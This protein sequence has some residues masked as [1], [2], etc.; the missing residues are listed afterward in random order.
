MRSD[1]FAKLVELKYTGGLFIPNNDNA[2]ALCD[3]LRQ[4]DVVSFH[5]VTQRDVKFHRC[6][7]QLLGF[8]YEYLPESFKRKV[9]KDRFYIFLKHL[10]GNYDVVYKFKDGSEMIEY[11]SI[12]FG[13]M[14][15]KQFEEYIANQLPFIYANILGAYFD[16]DTLNSIISTI[17]EEFRNM[18]KKLP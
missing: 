3:L 5:E 10:E 2:H 16:L 12:A 14:S 9:P 4:G 6:Y 17:E 15:Q 11:R 1:D 13:K 18:L 8:I 7:F